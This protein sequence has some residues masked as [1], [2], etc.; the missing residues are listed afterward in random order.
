MTEPHAH[1]RTRDLTPS[2]G[3]EVLGVDL[4]QPLAED[5]FDALY[6][7]FLERQVLL[8]RGQDLPPAAQVR[9][10]RQFGQLQVHVMNQYLTDAHPELYWLSNVGP[11]GKPNGRHPD[12]G[13]LAW[14]TD[15][16][17]QPNTALATIL[18]AELVP[19][20]GAGGE[21]HFCNMADAH[22]AVVARRGSLDRL[23][24]V[25][26]LD[27]SR[28]R[29]HPEEPLT[30]EQ[31]ASI[32]PVTH[33]VAR[34]HPETGRKVLYLGDHAETIEGMDYPAGRA[35]VDALNEEAIADERVLRQEW[36]AGDLMVWDNRSVVHRATPYDTAVHRR[37]IRRC[38][39]LGMPAS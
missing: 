34:V 5:A 38:T 28:N 29:R 2:I 23:R 10:G 16:S 35:L 17:W 14:H 27:F 24:A 36:R 32:P 22:D 18:Y 4:S 13:T 20:P 15:G 7:V 26:N 19:P 3:T 31:R 8:F 12:R 11:D 9:F 6:R 37:I 1:F 21:T 25:H 30:D 39:V 33:P